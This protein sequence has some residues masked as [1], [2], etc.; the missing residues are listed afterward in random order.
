MQE[1]HCC[2]CTGRYATYYR[3]IMSNLLNNFM[4]LLLCSKGVLGVY[5]FKKMC[6][7]AWY[8]SVLVNCVTG[9]TLL[10]FGNFPVEIAWAI[11]RILDKFRRDLIEDTFLSYLNLI[12]NLWSSL[13]DLMSTFFAYCSTSHNICILMLLVCK[14][15]ILCS[16][17]AVYAR[18]HVSHPLL[19]NKKKQAS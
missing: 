2:C 15:N 12:S 1:K 17:Q 13:W 16:K 8:G 4:V 11:L 14:L 5:G 3:H 7:F 9:S 6:N 10:K 19:S 18:T